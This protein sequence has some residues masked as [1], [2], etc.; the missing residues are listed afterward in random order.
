MVCLSLEAE[1]TSLALSQ[2]ATSARSS[3]CLYA[4]GHYATDEC[5]GSSDDVSEVR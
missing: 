5:P 2:N 3:H 4:N 1:P